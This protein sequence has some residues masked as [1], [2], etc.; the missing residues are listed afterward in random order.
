MYEY[1]YMYICE[2]LRYRSNMW[3]LDKRTHPCVCRGPKR[4][5]VLECPNCLWLHAHPLL[6]TVRTRCDWTVK[7]LAQLLA[8]SKHPGDVTFCYHSGRTATSSNPSL[9]RCQSKDAD[10]DPRFT[11]CASAGINTSAPRSSSNTCNRSL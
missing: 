1:A 5:A 4:A 6:I 10:R 2:Y 7:H 11:P 9:H 3:D 8:H